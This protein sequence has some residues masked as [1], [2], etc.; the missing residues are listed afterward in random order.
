MADSRRKMR[1]PGDRVSRR[2]A[3]GG[4]GWARAWSGRPVPRR[5]TF[6][7]PILG[8]A[9]STPPALRHP[10][11]RLAATPAPGS[12]AAPPVVLTLGWRPSER[13]A[14]HTSAVPTQAQARRGHGWATR[15]GEASLR[16]CSALRRSSAGGRASGRL[17]TPRLCP[18]RPKPAGAMDGPLVA[19]EHPCGPAPPYAAAR[20]E[21]ERAA[22]WAHLGCAHAG[23]SPQGPWM[24]LRA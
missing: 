20:R 6:A 4:Q 5:R 9:H 13:P 17:G 1:A 22:G 8:F 15:R 3:W 18:R 10:W 21:A 23:P 12:P 19:A 24:A 14:G 2:V 7:A 11:L 16:A